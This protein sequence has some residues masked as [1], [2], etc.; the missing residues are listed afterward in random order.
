MVSI[1]SALPDGKLAAGTIARAATELMLARPDA[2]SDVLDDEALRVAYEVIEDTFASEPLSLASLYD[3]LSFLRVSVW[4]ARNFGERFDGSI[5]IW[6][7]A[8]AALTSLASSDGS[9]DKQTGTCA[10]GANDQPAESL[11]TAS[12]QGLKDSSFATFISAVPS[13]DRY[14][15]VMSQFYTSPNVDWRSLGFAL[16]EITRNPMVRVLLND[17]RSTRPT[18]DMTIQPWRISVTRLWRP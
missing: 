10:F 8:V 15:L 2:L 16:V 7:L 12:W 1:L 13:G 11:V 5:G 9:Y 4:A 3:A 17:W 14:S 6:C 18:P